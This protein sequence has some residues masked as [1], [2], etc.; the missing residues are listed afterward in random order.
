MF[1]FEL[2][3]SIVVILDLLFG[4]PSYLLHPVRI[5]GYFCEQSEKVFRKLTAS[6]AMAGMLSFATVL[7]ITICGT[8]LVLAC[9]NLYSPL[10]VQI[11][12]I[13]LLYTTV[14]ARDLVVHSRQVYSALQNSENLD[15]ARNAVAQIVG[16]DTEELDKKGIIR[17]CIETVAENMVDGVTAPLF[18][19]VFFSL[20]TTFSSVNPLFT[21]AIGAMGYKA[22]NTMDSMFGYK[23]EKYLHFG[24]VAAKFDDFVNFIPARVSALMLIPAAFVLGLNWKN[25]FVIFK[26]DRLAHAS[27][28]AAHPEA[29]FAGALDIELGGVSVYLGK[30]IKKPTLGDSNRPVNESDILLAN[31]LMLLGSFFFLLLLLAGRLLIIQLVLP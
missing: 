21:A 11:T 7:C 12:A 22:V 23:N 5:I 15:D 19:A 4:D 1:L 14:A 27:P 10:I 3:I 9:I 20:F 24:K 6:D 2:H 28:N 25:A 17:A 16:R 31:R 13:L 18:F 8:T 30:E 26:R 29:A